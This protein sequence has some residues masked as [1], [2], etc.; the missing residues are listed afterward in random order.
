M[1]K[2][3]SIN[4][5]GFAFNIEEQAYQILSEYLKA[6]EQNFKNDDDC[7]EIMD[8]IE[9]RIAELFQEELSDRKEV[10]INTDV[11]NVISIMGS[12]EEY[13]SDEEQP[14]KEEPKF[15]KEPNFTMGSDQKKKRLYRDESDAVVGGVCL[16]LAHYFGVDVVLI[17]IIFVLCFFFGAGFLLYIILWVVMPSAKTTGEILE[18]KGESVTLDSIKD[19]VK[20]AKNSF[21]DSTKG[22][23]KNIKNAVDKGVRTGSRIL[24]SFGRLL[25]GAFVLGG[26]FGLLFIVLILFGNT[27]ML[28]MVGQDEAHDLSSILEVIFAD[29]RSFW[30]ILSGTLVALIPVLALIFLGVKLLFKIK[31]KD[32]KIG[33]AMSL[34][35]FLAIGMLVLYVVELALS[36]NNYEEISINLSKELNDSDTLYIDVMEDDV[37]PE[38]FEF[39]EIRNSSAFAKI[40][41]ERVFLGFPNLDIITTSDTAISVVLYKNSY[42]FSSR[43]SKERA[44]KVE[45]DHELIDNK[46]LLGRYFSFLKTDKYRKQNVT[47]EVRV[48]K[49]TVLKFGSKIDKIV[50]DVDNGYHHYSQDYKNSQWKADEYNELR[51]LDCNYNF[52]GY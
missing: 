31:T 7:S 25:G 27:G 49:N 36:S 18:M 52:D 1:N 32:K 33:V 19:H 12:P 50:V 45:Y 34:I 13:L 17:R 39:N 35:W 14:E 47:V 30:V 51:C 24:N 26:I 21:V 2:T 22:T 8:D 9:A 29:G 43:D 40:K 44:N 4:I 46:L 41:E 48:P 28:P 42:G 15:S 16:G 20:D 10:I 38:D 23:K 6:I 5:A 37:F 3:I 11:D